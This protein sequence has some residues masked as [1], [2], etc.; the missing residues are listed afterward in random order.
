MVGHASERHRKHKSEVGDTSK[1]ETVDEVDKLEEVDKPIEVR[2][3]VKESKESSPEVEIRLQ[4]AMKELKVQEN[5]E[6]NISQKMEEALGEL[7]EMESKK[8]TTENKIKEAIDSLEEPV[9]D[10]ESQLRIKRGSKS[11]ILPDYESKIGSMEEVDKAIQQHPHV[12]KGLSPESY[13]SCERYIRV[14]SEEDGVSSKE[15]AETEELDEKVVEKWRDGVKPKAIHVIEGLET[16]RLEHEVQIPEEALEHRIT[17]QDVH[18]VTSDAME[19][20]NHTVKEL[21]DVVQDIHQKIDSPRPNSVHYAEL[22]DS[23]KPLVEDR[24][25]DLAV[26]I[27]SNREAIQSELNTRLG[28]DDIPHHE[29]RI[30]VTDSRLYYWHINTSPDEWVNVLADQKF[31]MS[32][33][34]KAKLIDGMRVHLHI[35]EGGQISEYYLNDIINQMSGLEKPAANRIRKYDNV[36]SLDGEI[37][38]LIGDL[39]GKSLEDFKTVITHMGTK[40]AARVS[41][42]KF[43]DIHNF[44]IRFVAIGESDGHVDI[45]GRFSYYEKNKERRKIA[46]DFFQEFGDF[47]VKEYKDGGKQ[48]GLPK[49]YG[50]MAEKW[51]IP[52]GDKGIHNRGLHDSVTNETL[53][54]KVNYPIEMVGEDGCITGTRV[55]IRRHHVLHAGSKEHIYRDRYGI[56]PAVSQKHIDLVRD[57]GT[58]KD[59]GL[60]YKPGD[61]VVL[62]IKELENLEKTENSRLSKTAK[63]LIQIVNDNPNRLLQDEVN[64]MIQPLGIEMNPQ[65]IHLRYY[66]DSKR[67]SLVSSAST[68]TVDDTLR[69][70]F[71][72]PPNHPEKMKRAVNLVQDYQTKAQDVK[73]RIINDGLDIHPSWKEYGF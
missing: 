12:K 14:I 50:A 16:K 62:T 53:E 15:I 4:D 69:W 32:K 26:E 72:A 70:V 5:K 40:E 64:K 30:G 20:E 54:N 24:L 22:Y 7:R 35:R 10:T 68:S 19:K 63:E 51:G 21:T 49:I 25:R 33:E 55:T 8:E 46:T 27:R 61:V 52:R 13:E 45:Y 17:P 23:E 11:D 42:L 57:E 34:D 47:V 60:N 43:P 2:S 56:K 6:D 58:D 31:Y 66:R 67:L 18:E 41:N 1:K 59:V 28:L 48:V 65:S 39:K 44:R 29:V 9:N 71:I 38:H 73:K 37:M 36:Y 3:E